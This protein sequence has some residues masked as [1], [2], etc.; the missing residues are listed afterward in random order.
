MAHMSLVYTHTTKQPEWIQEYT[1]LEYLHIEGIFFASLMSL[2]EGMFDKMSSLAFVHLGFHPILSTLPSFDGLT[3]LKSLTLAM[4]FSLVELPTFD[5]AHNLER[6]LLVSLV[7]VNSLPDLTPVKKVNMFTVA[8][9]A[10]WCCNGFLGSCDLQNPNCQVHPLWGTP[11]ATC[12]SSNRTDDHPSDGTLEVL[13]KFSRTIC[14][15]LLLPGK[16]DVPPSEDSMRQ[17]NGT[18]Y[19][20]C[21]W[22]GV[23]EA[24]CYSSRLM[25]ISCSANP[26]PI[27]MRRHQ[28]QC[29]IGDRCD[30][31]YE[32]WLGCI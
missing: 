25:A 6:L 4:L 11:A 29:G 32:A 28:I 16:I 26:Y 2:L 15:D 30:P 23:K 12:L 5:T 31:L 9:R 24:M 10:P 1:H 27:E 21:E 14:Y 17:C 19:R 22:P 7:N 20:R 13:K 8:D 3:R 18:L